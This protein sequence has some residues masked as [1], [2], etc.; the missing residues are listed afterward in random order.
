M[1]VDPLPVRRDHV[2]IGLVGAAEVTDAVGV[3]IAGPRRSPAP[4][5]AML[6][7]FAGPVAS[8]STAPPDRRGA[9]RPA[10]R[11]RERAA[12]LD[13]PAR[14]SVPMQLAPR[15]RRWRKVDP[16]QAYGRG[17]L[18]LFS[19]DGIRPWQSAC[20]GSKPWRATTWGA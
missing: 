12:K 19:S 11:S 8:A 18:R 13:A 17:P 14:R 4:F 15:T 9:D 7:Q 5:A 16:L 10:P 1:T 6:I 2:A 3:S 20:R